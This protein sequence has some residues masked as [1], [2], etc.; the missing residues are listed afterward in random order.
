MVSRSFDQAMGDG[1]H[2]GSSSMIADLWESAVVSPELGIDDDMLTRCHFPRADE[3][4]E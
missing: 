4:I 1:M 2:N 3:V